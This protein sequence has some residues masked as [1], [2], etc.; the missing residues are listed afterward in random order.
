MNEKIQGL[1]GT[2][3]EATEQFFST[4]RRREP[5]EPERALLAALLQDAIED[6]RK[7]KQARDP[8]GRQR[9]REVDAWINESASDWIFSFKNVCELLNLEPEY[10]RR[11][12]DPRKAKPHN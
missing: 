10:V 11:A 3:T 5:I 6:Y 2:D 12:L 9:F 1:L 4:F 7:F 8:E